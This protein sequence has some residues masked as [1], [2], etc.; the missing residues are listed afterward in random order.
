MHVLVKLMFT[1][2]KSFFEG[3]RLGGGVTVCILFF[4]GLGLG[5][6]VE[7]CRDAIFFCSYTSHINCTTCTNYSNSIWVQHQLLKLHQ[8][9]QLSQLKG[10]RQQ[11]QVLLPN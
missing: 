1:Y 2:I 10:L 7:P 5:K 9:K 4:M 11:V 6:V 3:G 8:H